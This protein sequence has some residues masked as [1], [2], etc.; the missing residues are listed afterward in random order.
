MQ[1]YNYVDAAYLYM[2]VYI[3]LCFIDIGIKNYFKKGSAKAPI[4]VFLIVVIF[5]SS[6]TSIS[7]QL[8]PKNF[9]PVKWET[10]NN[11]FMVLSLL[12][13]IGE[14]AKALMM[15]GLGKRFLLLLPMN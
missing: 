14:M 6:I 1:W 2:T 15:I 13:E 9:K 3:T 7:A 8:M 4:A 12:L 11:W 5:L 10:L